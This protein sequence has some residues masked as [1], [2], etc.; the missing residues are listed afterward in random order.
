M[1][2]HTL[3]LT[4]RRQKARA[5]K[6]SSSTFQRAC[7]Q[8]C[9]TKCRRGH[10]VVTSRR[11]LEQTVLTDQSNRMSAE[12][13]AFI[14]VDEPAWLG[15]TYLRVFCVYTHELKVK[16]TT[17]RCRYGARI[18]TRIAVQFRRPIRASRYPTI[19]SGSWDF[20]I[21]CA[22][23]HLCIRFFWLKFT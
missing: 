3:Q 9:V 17:R 11:S 1:R 14:C 7:P 4:R 19:T 23:R 5:S 20:A 12:H 21:A 13:F 18:V 10:E 6:I 2:K 8:R 15:Y 16:A 22:I